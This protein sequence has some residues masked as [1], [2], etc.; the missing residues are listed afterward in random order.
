MLCNF[1]FFSNCFKI[2]SIFL[3]LFTLLFKISSS[4]VFLI[5]FKRPFWFLNCLTYYSSSSLQRFSVFDSSTYSMI[6][7]IYTLIITFFIIFFIIYFVPSKC[8]PQIIVTQNFQLPFKQLFLRTFQTIFYLKRFTF[9]EF[10]LFSTFTLVTPSG[11]RVTWNA[12]SLL[13]GSDKVK[14]WTFQDFNQKI[15]TFSWFLPQ[16]GYVFPRVFLKM[17]TFSRTHFRNSPLKSIIMR[18]KDF[19]LL[20]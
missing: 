13:Q 4:L 2:C 14:S 20:R 10:K 11:L 8:K 6:D 7:L 18:G 16:K 1:W 5:K 12:S 9:W 15:C 3:L 17:D 19:C